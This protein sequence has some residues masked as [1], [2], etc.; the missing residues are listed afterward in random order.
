M[1]QGTENSG[2]QITT[3]DIAAIRLASLRG[4]QAELA[5]IGHSGQPLAAVRMHWRI[6][7]RL[8]TAGEQATWR[9]APV[10]QTFEL[11]QAND[12]AKP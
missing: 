3:A 10:T 12:P 2:S 6:W 11:G 9:G 1:G 4:D 5:L 7:Q 8:A